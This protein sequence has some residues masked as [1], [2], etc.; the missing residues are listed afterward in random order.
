MGKYKQVLMENQ[1]LQANI[2]SLRSDLYHIRNRFNPN[3]LPAKYKENYKTMLIQRDKVLCCNRYKWNIPFFNISSQQLE[4]YYYNYGSLCYFVRN[5]KLQ[6]ARFSEGG[7]LNEWGLLDKIEPIGFDGNSYGFKI[8]VFN[9]DKTDKNKVA[10]ISHDY[11][12]LNMCLPRSQINATTTIND[13]TE[14]YAQIISNVKTSIHKA[15]ALCPNAEQADYVREQVKDILS[16]S[17]PIPTFA[18]SKK[19]I[20]NLVEMFNLNTDYDPTTFTYLLEYYDKVRRAFNGIPSP[21][22]FEKNER[23]ITSE[24]QNTNAHVTL[25]LLDGY[26]NRKA[27]VEKVKQYLDFEGV[28][29]FDV[30]INTGIFKEEPAAI[31]N[32]EMYGEMQNPEVPETNNEKEEEKENV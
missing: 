21:D 30:E 22:S 14:V 5:G 29:E 13:Q 11:T 26:F 7:D 15:I 6:I 19:D 32:N 18:G 20:E 3:E 12:A 4:T 27:T 8:N 17:N 2:E 31:D 1:L 28:E 25:T 24:V 23:L 9:Y 16:T 10:I